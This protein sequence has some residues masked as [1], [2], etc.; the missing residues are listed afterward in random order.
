MDWTALA[1]ACSKV[2]TAKE[3]DD[4]YST[5]FSDARSLPAPWQQGIDTLEV[6]TGL[7]SPTTQRILFRQAT[8]QPAAMPRYWRK[9]AELAPAAGRAL[10][11]DLRIAIDPGHIGGA[12]ALMEERLLSFQTG[13]R[14]M[15]GES[16]LQVAKLVKTKL[17]AEGAQVFLVRDT[18]EPV[19]T[20]RPVD[21]HELAIRTLA[22]LGVPQPVESYA[23]LEGQA[24][25]FTVQ[26]QAEKLFY[27]VSE[28]RAR[29]KKVN[30]VL[31]PDLVLCLHFNAEPWGNAT[32]PQYSPVNHFHTLINGCYAPDELQ[33]QD[34]RYEM[35]QRLFS[36]VVDEELPLAEEVAKGMATA[37]R[38][39]PYIYTQGQA[40]HVGSTPY[41]YARNLLANRLYRCP[42]IYLEPYVM[43]NQE[44]YNRMRLGQYAGRT[45]VNG[46][47]MPSI[48]DDYAEGVAQG[49]INY[50]RAK[51]RN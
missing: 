23:G 7:I 9:A 51:R 34:V 25:M 6:S 3:F 27:R 17:E 37:T 50:Y 11:S 28:I 14:I 5:I 31:K 36:R 44:T 16:S 4:A 41:V 1:K 2:L 47:L 30:E 24:K 10:L 15:E 38:L 35:L 8:E 40:R 29:A 43:N 45:L 20:T 39:D 46:R 48:I 13:E 22:E 33:L 18:E 49:L 21:F 42:V 19:T 32:A 26:W 12:Y